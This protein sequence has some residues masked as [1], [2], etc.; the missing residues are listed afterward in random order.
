[1]TP[2]L[3]TIKL[4]HLIIVKVKQT[5][6]LY[7]IHTSKRAN[8]FKYTVV[9]YYFLNF[10]KN[11]LDII[12]HDNLFEICNGLIGFFIYKQRN[13]LQVVRRLLPSSGNKT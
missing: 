10:T 13:N 1:M 2:Y 7:L 3:V 12:I 9:K 4:F 6:K 11:G 5:K 8:P